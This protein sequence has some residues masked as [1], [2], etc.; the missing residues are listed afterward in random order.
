MKL[1]KVLPLIACLGFVGCGESSTESTT[2]SNKVEQTSTNKV[3]Q[4]QANQAKEGSAANQEYVSPLPDDAPVYKVAT[5]GKQLPFTFKN[6]SGL[7][8]GID[9]DIIRAIGELEGFKVEFYQEPWNG[10]FATV[11]Q[12]ER[13]LAVSSI[14]YTDERAGKYT[15]S[16]PYMFVPSAIVYKKSKFNIKGLNDLEGLKVGALEGSIQIEEVKSNVKDITVI[17]AKSMYLTYT[18]L[19][20][21]ETDAVISDMQELQYR[22]TEYPDYE[23]EFVSYGSEDDPSSHFVMM[24]NPN[25]AELK[26]K[27]NDGIDKLKAQGKFDEIQ[28]K[29][30]KKKKK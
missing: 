2:E 22:S 1:F 21:D 29:W 20:R 10:L 26:E 3:E 11:K 27:V 17:P 15:L 8:Q 14:S 25:D 12:G 4:V 7:L 5:T 6:E 24:I 16:K 19:L 13:D 28:A 23:F 9:I 30:L 18:Q